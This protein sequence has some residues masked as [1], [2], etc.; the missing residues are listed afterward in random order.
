MSAAS[1]VELFSV[2]SE[3]CVDR[4]VGRPRTQNPYNPACALEHFAAWEYGWDDADYLLEVRGREEAAR[5]LREA[6]R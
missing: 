3:G 4:F 1:F 6:A 2:V 5:W